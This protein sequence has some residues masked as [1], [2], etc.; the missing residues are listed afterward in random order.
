MSRAQRLLELLQVLGQHR[1]AVAGQALAEKLGVSLRTLYRDIDTLRAQGARIEAEAGLGFVLLPG[2]MLPPLMFSH[3]EVQAVLLGM[4]W[5]AESGDAA[6]SAAAGTALAKIAAV[7]PEDIETVAAAGNLLVGPS[8]TPDSTVDLA[9]VRRAI[10]DERKAE[11]TYTDGSGEG[12]RRVVWP[13][14]LA[15]FDGAQV[16]AAW[17]ELRQDFRHFSCDRIASWRTLDTAYPR[18]RHVLLAEW[19]LREGIGD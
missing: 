8:R 4:R 18:R 2:F 7:L 19:R 9:T 1:R 15:F 16:A 17:C 6:L 3:E 11:I 12:S 13:F 14:A 5:V 10:R